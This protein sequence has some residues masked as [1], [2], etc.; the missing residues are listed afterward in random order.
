MVDEV[1]NQ[2]E[3]EVYSLPAALMLQHRISDEVVTH[4]NK[5][6]DDLKKSEHRK[7]AAD[8]LVGQIHQGEQ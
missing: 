6:L 5:Y 4:L 2:I 7:S 8:F 3:Y 1:S